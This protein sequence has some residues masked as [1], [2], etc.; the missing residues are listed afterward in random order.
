[1][2]GSILFYVVSVLEL[3]DYA[4]M[5][6]TSK[7]LAVLQTLVGSQ[8]LATCWNFALQSHILFGVW[9]WRR[10]LLHHRDVLLMRACN[11]AGLNLATC[12]WM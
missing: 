10:T 7:R 9:P 12:V 2:C 1:M 6:Y 11:L 3:T 8:S 4:G 5:L